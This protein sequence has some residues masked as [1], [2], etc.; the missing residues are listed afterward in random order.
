MNLGLRHEYSK[1]RDVIRGSSISCSGK[2]NPFMDPVVHLGTKSSNSDIS[3][4]EACTAVGSGHQ[5][6]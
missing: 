6:C 2:L 4:S 3:S 5:G 1:H